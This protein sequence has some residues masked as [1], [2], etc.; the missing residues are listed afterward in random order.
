VLHLNRAQS[1]A[2]RGLFDGA[3]AG[4][5]G[6]AVEAMAATQA[7]F[8]EHRPL[9]SLAQHQSAF[10]A[11]VIGPDGLGHGLPGPI[12][13]CVVS[14]LGRRECLEAIVE[15]CRSRGLSCPPVIGQRLESEPG[16]ESLDPAE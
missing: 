11:A 3:L 14:Y 5:T 6:E 9:P 2:L 10:P 16:V 4:M 7:A 13:A 15:S 8:L 12:A 1:K